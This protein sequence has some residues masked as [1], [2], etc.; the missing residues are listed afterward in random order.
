MDKRPHNEEIGGT[1][2]HVGDCYVWAQIRYL[3]SP[4]HYRECLPD[5]KLHFVSSR[6]KLVTLDTNQH[7]TFATI[8]YAA[9]IAL[10]SC[11]F[12]LWVTRSLF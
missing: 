10:L 8:C 11:M 1:T 7:S 5:R 4:T 9:A 2:V 12:L 6:I 3:D